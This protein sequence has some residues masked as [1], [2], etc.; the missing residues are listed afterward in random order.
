MQFELPAQLRGPE[1]GRMVPLIVRLR[2]E[3]EPQLAALEKNSLTSICP[4]LRIGGS[5]GSFGD[6]GIE[7]LK[8]DAGEAGCD[9]VIK[10]RLW[11]SWSDE[12]IYTELRKRV[13]E[14]LQTMLEEAGV[15]HS[16]CLFEAPP[17]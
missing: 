15:P 5:L 13:T 7:Y 16:P 11:D 3:L 17:A 6:D 8:V 12:Q 1:C 10:P 14:A 2:K 9:V 4:I